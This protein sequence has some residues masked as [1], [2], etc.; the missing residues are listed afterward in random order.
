MFAPVVVKPYEHS[1]VA[2][3][4]D[5]AAAT[6]AAEVHAGP[7]P[8][9]EAGAAKPVALVIVVADHCFP[10]HYCKVGKVKIRK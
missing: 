5:A 4:A 3:S 2:A 9:T 8:E 6:L 10:E 1:P 7:R